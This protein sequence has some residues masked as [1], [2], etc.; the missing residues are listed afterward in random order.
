MRRIIPLAL[1]SLALSAC[2]ERQEAP[3]ESIDGQTAARQAAVYLVTFH[4]DVDV[5]ATTRDLA[6]IHGLA[7][8]SV[9][10]HAA[11]GFSAVVPDARL[12]AL[13]ADPRI[14]II[15]A[16][17]P[18]ALIRP[19]EDAARPGSGGGGGQTTPWGITRVG[20]AGDGT[21]KTAWVIDTGIDLAHSDLN[22]SKNCHANFVTRGKDSPADGNGHGTHVAGT[23]GAKNNGQD[24]VG[25]AANAFV[26]A[27]RVLDNS[28]SGTWEGVMNGIDYVAASAASGDVANMSLGG[29]GANATLEKA[30]S[31]A[32]AKGVRM[33][34]AA[35]NDGAHASNFTPA[36]VNGTNIY[37][38]SAIASNNCM[39]SWSNYGNPPVD[40]A[41]PGA[42]I[43]STKKGGGTTTMSGTSMAAPHAAGVL[44]LGNARSNGS[45]CN[46]PDGN[47]DPIISR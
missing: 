13:R 44:L 46:D 21:G 47:P 3:F 35:G 42:S 23:I 1:A 40:Y 33:V 24:V 7:V 9:R 2:A 15:E 14:A 26:C 27:V 8:R 38:I 36:R 45:A 10:L 41:A 31:D 5:P 39:P 43:L 37:T 19:I 25:V 22:T 11:R 32:A 29:S 28:G 16:D 17:G 30:V 34:L 6:R 12:A 4:D 20:G 18:V